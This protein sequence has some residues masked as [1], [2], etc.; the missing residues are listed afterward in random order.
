MGSIRQKPVSGRDGGQL[1]CTT[2]CQC[3]SS[4][5]LCMNSNRLTF[6]D[7]QDETRGIML[8]IVRERERQGI[9]TRRNNL[10]G[11]TPTH[12]DSCNKKNRKLDIKTSQNYS[13]NT[14]HVEHKTVLSH[15]LLDYCLFH[16]VSWLEQAMWK[17]PQVLL[18]IGKPTVTSQMGTK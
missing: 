17:V 4:S 14:L 2:V 6:R 10:Q 5:D 11:D 18:S 16:N 7:A 12:T 8:K 9:I 3:V 1:K 13:S 15:P